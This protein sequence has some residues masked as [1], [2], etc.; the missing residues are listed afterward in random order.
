M[1]SRI[2]FKISIITVVLNRK[3]LLEKT[4]ESIISQSNNNF[5]IVIIDGGSTDGTI[6]IIKKYSDNI[7]YWISEPDKGIYDAMNKGLKSATGDFVWFLNAGDEIYS[8]DTLQKIV[9]LNVLPD[10]FYGDVEYIDENRK[11]LGTRILKKPPD[12][13]SWRS[14]LKGMVV[15]HQSFIIKKEKSEFYNPDYKYCA[16]IDW[17]INS[18]KNCEDVYN[19]KMILSKFLT[20]GY[21]KRN[22]IKSNK[23]RYR[24]LRKNFGFFPVIWS[25]IILGITFAGYFFS[26]KKRFY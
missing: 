25:H 21:S 5:E 12:N 15:S 6:E 3:E 2:D 9:S 24:I 11:E 17:M 7:S 23:E 22:I 20:G 1:N 18:M 26:N 4:I 13:F 19:T 16:D 10:V 14:L 8:D